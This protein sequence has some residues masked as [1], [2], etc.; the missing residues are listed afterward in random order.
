MSSELTSPQAQSAQNVEQNPTP[1]AQNIE[2]IPAEQNVDQQ[3]NE[4]L[5][6]IDLT[7]HDQG[8]Q[9]VEVGMSTP[10]MNV[11]TPQNEHN[12]AW[13]VDLVD[14]LHNEHAS[15][16]ELYDS[17]PSDETPDE[18]WVIKRRKCA[19]QEPGQDAHSAVSLPVLEELKALPPANTTVELWTGR[20][21]VQGDDGMP[22]AEYFELAD[23]PDV[24]MRPPHYTYPFDQ[25]MY[26]ADQETPI[27]RMMLVAVPAP[28]GWRTKN[29]D[30]WYSSF[31][32]FKMD[33]TVYLPGNS[34]HFTNTWFHVQYTCQGV[35]SDR[36]DEEQ[37]GSRRRF[38]TFWP[39]VFVASWDLNQI[40]PLNGMNYQSY[41]HPT[42]GI[43]CSTQTIPSLRYWRDAHGRLMFPLGSS[44]KVYMKINNRPYFWIEFPN[45][46]CSVEHMTHFQ[47]HRFLNRE[48]PFI[49]WDP[50]NPLRRWCKVWNTLADPDQ[51]PFNTLVPNSEYDEPNF[52]KVK[53]A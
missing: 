47:D 37:Y 49:Y 22:T 18:Y 24:Y 23:R 15:D 32:E 40:P 41:R 17:L 46:G 42:E 10:E 29:G 4:P 11:T 16:D 43:E 36:D 38:R 35:S 31:K 25:L 30:M 2:H 21:S 7:L 45:T 34:G 6:V 51:V 26:E 48:W 53:V 5:N 39:K 27:T 50:Y 28:N 20:I 3:N 1:A 9:H 33:I 12:P 14:N 8:E 13:M 44:F 19:T 52:T